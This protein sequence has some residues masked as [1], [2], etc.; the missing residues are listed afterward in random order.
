MAAMGNWVAGVSPT[1]VF[2]C[3]EEL[4]QIM[5][6]SHIPN[7]WLVN[8]LTSAVESI[9]SPTNTAAKTLRNGQLI[10]ITPQGEYSASGMLI[11]K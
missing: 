9:E 1:G 6:D 5:D 10:I 8:S 11:N 4:D 2:Y 3:P 7:G